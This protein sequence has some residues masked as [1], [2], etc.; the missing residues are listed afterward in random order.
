MI[1]LKLT[2][3]KL[4]NA[5]ILTLLINFT[6]S[7]Q[8]GPINF[9]TPGFGASWT[10]TVFE[11]FPTNPS[12]T[13]TAN[14]SPTGINPSSTVAKFNALVT[15][16]PWAG[17]E[18]THGAGIGTFT[19]TPSNCIVK[20]MVYKPVISD[21][22]IKFATLGNAS[23]GEIKVANTLINQWE[24]LTFNFTAVLNAPSS[25]GID[26]II[27]FP[28]F[29][30]NPSR[31]SNNICYFDNITF[32]SSTLSNPT[33]SVAA[34]TPTAAQ[35]NV[36]SL[37][38][39]TYTNV[40]VNTWL[41]NWSA[42]NTSTLQIAG[43]DTRLY[44]NLNFVGIETTGANMIN[45]NC[46]THFNIDIYT[47][48]MTQFRV[49]LVDWGANGI[50]QGTPNDD[51]EAEL[52][53][54]PTLNGWNTYNIPLSN[55]ASGGLVNKAH[56]A[57]IIL[58]GNPV[59]N[60]IL[61]VDNIYF[62]KSNLQS[63]NVSICNGQSYTI[64]PIGM[65]SFTVQGGSGSAIV[66]PT[67]NTTYTVTGTNSLTGCS[68]N[69]IISLSVNPSPTI[70]ITGNQTICAGE[71]VNLNAS[72]ANTYTWNN[73]WVA[74]NISVTP[75]TSTIFYVMGSNSNGCV[76]T[77]SA[78]IIV[79]ECTGIN[80][81]ISQ[82][83]IQIYPNPNEGVF[84]INLKSYDNCFIKITNVLGQII[85]TQKAEMINDFNIKTFEKGIYFI[86]I[87]NN[88]QPIYKGSI[89]KE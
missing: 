66:S 81:I 55:F 24:E 71:Y 76:G 78:Q 4:F 47:P 25:S 59:G 53:Y 36:I 14:P 40:G 73:S 44:S 60:G 45:A 19:L 27:I 38:S 77:A 42:G 49:K 23:T 89:I 88:N 51:T 11:N 74:N 58:S 65:T 28:D 3:G 87:L 63:N 69:G 70:S 1:K 21:V 7:S 85:K 33:P 84:T 6:A 82:N 18:T 64:N 83:E 34:P 30:M 52:T 50:Y 12:L 39:N 57:Q 43:N 13:I 22:G 31:T 61:Y 10:W 15:G 54:T 48:N 56:I 2:I 29:K 5:L 86:T 75:S 16:N 41:T 72:G 17:C 35:A 80:S 67:I 68:S 79:S 26:Q 20:M 32:S 8:N 9:E 46:M 37:F 62:S